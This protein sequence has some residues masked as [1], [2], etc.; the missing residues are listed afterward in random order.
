MIG[1][2]QDAPFCRF[3]VNMFL[4][5]RNLPDKGY[6]L[7]QYAIARSHEGKYAEQDSPK[8]RKMQNS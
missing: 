8:N 3:I 7:D 5:Y 6:F 4:R 1:S 2:L